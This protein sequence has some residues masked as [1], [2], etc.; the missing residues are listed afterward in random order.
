MVGVVRALGDG[1]RPPLAPSLLLVLALS[2]CG[3]APPRDWVIRFAP[4]DPG[5]ERNISRS[6]VQDDWERI[7]TRIVSG[8]ACAADPPRTESEV[9]GPDE[10]GYDVSQRIPRG[11]M[12]EAT[13]MVLAPGQY[14]VMAWAVDE[15]EAL[16]A[17]S[18]LV[19]SSPGAGA[20]VSELRSVPRPIALEAEWRVSFGDEATRASASRVFVRR[21]PGSCPSS[22]PRTAPTDRSITIPAGSHFAEPLT[23]D[24]AEPTALMAWAERDADCTIAAWGCTDGPGPPVIETVLAPLAPAPDFCDDPRACRVAATGLACDHLV[25]EETVVGNTSACFRSTAGEVFC[26]GS[27]EGA[28]MT[29]PAGFVP[30]QLF[31]RHARRSSVPGS[32]DRGDGYCALD[33]AGSVV[34]W[35]DAFPFASTFLSTPT[36]IARSALPAGDGLPIVLTLGLRFGCVVM[37]NDLSGGTV[38]CQGLAGDPTRSTLVGG[39]GPGPWVLTDAPTGA[40]NDIALLA[41]GAVHSCASN[42]GRTYC[43]GDER[44]AVATPEF[45]VQAPLQFN[46]GR[47]AVLGVGEMHA[48]ALAEDGYVQCWG[49]DFWG[50]LEP[51]FE[52]DVRPP[53]CAGLDY[54]AMLARTDCAG[55]ALHALYDG[56]HGPISPRGSYD[57]AFADFGGGFPPLAPPAECDR[58]QDVDR[59]PRLD[60]VLEVDGTALHA[61]H[62]AVGAFHTCAI[63]SAV[64][65]LHPDD[66]PGR[67]LCWGDDYENQIGGLGPRAGYQTHGNAAWVRPCDGEMPDPDAFVERAIDLAAG[68]HRT[69]ATD[70]RGDV[71]CWGGPSSTCAARPSVLP[72][73]W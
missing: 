28:P 61:T 27:I 4:G 12:P 5:L 59:E 65:S 36:G 66:A 62:L 22:P 18:C 6:G 13:S 53:A 57:E 38:Y 15:H 42:H 7:G 9:P 2:A 54:Y 43:W 26:E 56:Q 71:V 20:I 67:V 33:A 46:E 52:I 72:L 34:C 37:S 64:G 39:S 35:G 48:C 16:Y 1:V 50:A 31:G 60:C 29:M 23:F 3:T 11:R 68:T 44:V 49:S 69:C 73:V 32:I 47:Y 25:I 30:E 14:T 8:A 51:R 70:E 63:R 41:S 19:V 40:G 24:D 10:R 45:P 17:W 21:A 55:Y 58:M